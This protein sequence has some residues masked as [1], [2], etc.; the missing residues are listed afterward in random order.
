MTRGCVFDIITLES[1]ADLKEVHDNSPQQ[2]RKKGNVLILALASL[3]L[4]ANQF[5]GRVE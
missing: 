2:V 1:R 5:L 4:T 3:L